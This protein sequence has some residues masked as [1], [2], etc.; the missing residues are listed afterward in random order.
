M[1]AT[2]EFNLDDVNDRMAHLR[3]VK[4]TDMAIVL[5]NILHNLERELEYK[6]IQGGDSYS[7]MQLVIERIRELVLEHGIIIDELID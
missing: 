3:C 7:G 6:L 5:F 1:K 4:S 2:L